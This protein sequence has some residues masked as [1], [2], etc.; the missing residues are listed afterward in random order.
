MLT[1]RDIES[2]SSDYID[3][4][5]NIWQKMKYKF[6]LFMC[7]DCRRFIKHLKLTIYTYKNSLNQP[8]PKEKIDQVMDRIKEIN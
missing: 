8:T 4:D 5:L 6:H 1:C 7:V 2:K 3:N